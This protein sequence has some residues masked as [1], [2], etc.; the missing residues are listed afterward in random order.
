[1]QGR[2]EATANCQNCRQPRTPPK[3]AG[4]TSSLQRFSPL[5]VLGIGGNVLQG[6]PDSSTVLKLCGVYGE[7]ARSA[8]PCRLPLRILVKFSRSYQLASLEPGLVAGE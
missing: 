4:I 6:G 7:N 1:M 2:A 8:G 3:R 5:I